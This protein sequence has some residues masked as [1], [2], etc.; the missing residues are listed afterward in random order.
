LPGFGSSTP[1]PSDDLSIG[2]LADIVAATMAHLGCNA[3][4]AVFGNGLG[5]F[6]ALSVGIR[7]GGSFGPLIAS[8][9]G[10]T[11][12]PERTQ[13]FITMSELAEAG[14]MPA[15]ADVAVRRIFPEE[16]VARHPSALAERRA[17]L[18]T[19]DAGAFSRA[20]RAL[21]SLDLRGH[22]AAVRN[23]TLVIAGSIDQ[24]TP[25]EMAREVAS[26]IPGARLTIIPECGHC[27]QLEQPTALVD[28]IEAFLADQP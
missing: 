15:V 26:L 16:F 17:V 20:C 3:R 6:V 19:I 7:H 14:G 11:F 18:E 27:P 12:P 8:N 22:L 1:L 4:A 23:P 24:T 5:A 25:P 9:V 28:V 13:A 10:A 21:A 2:D